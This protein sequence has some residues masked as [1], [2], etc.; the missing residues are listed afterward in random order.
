MLTAPDGALGSRYLRENAP[1]LVP[2]IDKYGECTL[3]PEAPEKYFGTLV[4]GIISQQLPPDVSLEM[5]KRLEETTGTPVTPQAI[6]A[7]SDEALCACGIMQQ[8]VTYLKGFAAAVLNGEVTMD[9][10]A[11]MSDSEITKQLIKIK[12]LGQWTAE[13]FLLLALCRT[14]VAPTADFI[15]QKRVKEIFNLSTMPKR[16]QILELTE[17]WRPWR[18]LAVWYLWQA[19]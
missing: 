7:A 16:K 8:K 1:E 15:F 11:G 17:H 12:G 3:Q 18:S 5:V 13:M 19:E 2:F 4:T 14:D 9:K 6:A 10:F